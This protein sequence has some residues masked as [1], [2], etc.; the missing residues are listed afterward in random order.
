MEV[1]GRKAKEL[2][3]MFWKR[4]FHHVT[5]KNLLVVVSGVVDME[6]YSE[7]L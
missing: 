7:V 6:R 5:N 3:V 4:Q 1:V 2:G